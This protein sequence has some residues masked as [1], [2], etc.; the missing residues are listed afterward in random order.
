MERHTGRRIFMGVVK[1]LL[2]IVLAYLIAS[3]GK[4]AYDFG[5]GIFSQEAVSLPPGKDVAVT[6][7]EGM[8]GQELGQLLENKGLVK[9]AN[10]FYIQ[11]LLS[12]EK[13]KL[14]AGSYLL[15]T[16]QTAEEML[17]IMAGEAAET[18]E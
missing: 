13:E 5:Y 9:D 8:S 12:K 2:V 4:K 18:E 17:K 1:V 10:V 11:F 3:W 15:N 14:M 16:S 7:S 6:V